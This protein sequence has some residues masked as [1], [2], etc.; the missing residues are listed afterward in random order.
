M[1]EPT[2]YYQLADSDTVRTC[3]HLYGRG[4]TAQQAAAE[5]AYIYEHNAL[6]EWG[7]VVERFE[8]VN[9]G[10]LFIHRGDVQ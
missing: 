3:E 2:I 7:T 8:I 1:S 6:P 5:H 10:Y 9:D 4:A